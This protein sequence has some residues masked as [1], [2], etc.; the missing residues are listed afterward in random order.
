M[1]E[2]ELSEPFNQIEPLTTQ[3]P[4]KKFNIYLLI[5]LILITIIAATAIIILSIML[6]NKSND[7]NKIKEENENL[8]N[9]K[10]ENKK[11]KIENDKLKI[12]FT[13]LEN[14]FN[15]ISEQL[16][17][18]KYEY[19]NII[20]QYTN[21]NDT[22]N[23]IFNKYQELFLIANIVNPNILKENYT[24]VKSKVR[25]IDGYPDGTYDF[26]TKEPLNYEKGYEISFETYSRNSENY[27]SDED[28]DNI[29]Y[30]L[31]ALF[32]ANAQIG[33]YENNSMISYYL[34]DKNMSLA[35]AALFNQ[36]TI[37]DWGNNDIIVNTFNQ[38][39]YY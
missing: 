19:E 14:N 8:K 25:E 39:K 18:T 33:V 37:W 22:L 28:Y 34:E 1:S 12:D 5:L 23:D 32:G 16:N 4:K 26:V 3:T 30:K 20:N 2:K 31:S 13:N 35:I 15:D 9:L 17:T 11:L 38:P 29:V 10:D 7:Y 21:Q 6:K 27:Y 36:R 24:N